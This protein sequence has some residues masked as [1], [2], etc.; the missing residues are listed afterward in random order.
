MRRGASER[1]LQQRSVAACPGW[2]PELVS[3]AIVIHHLASARPVH[4]VSVHQV[5]SSP[6]TFYAS[7]RYHDAPQHHLKP[8]GIPC[9]DLIVNAL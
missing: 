1:L 8:A 2:V 3:S 4:F 6:T 9:L 5:T 7:F